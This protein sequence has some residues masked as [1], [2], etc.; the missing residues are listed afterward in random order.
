MNDE[1]YVK[2]MVSLGEELERAVSTEPY[3]PDEYNKVINAIESTHRVWY[4]SRQHRS[5]LPAIIIS[6]LAALLALIVAHSLWQS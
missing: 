4:R 5:I 2:I 1:T 3:D 6:F